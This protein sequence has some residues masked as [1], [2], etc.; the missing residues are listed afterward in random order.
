VRRPGR[1]SAQ[2]LLGPA[3]T[4]VRAH[5]AMRDY[6]ERRSRQRETKEA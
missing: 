6:I 3:A 2:T 4:V 5:D 1:C